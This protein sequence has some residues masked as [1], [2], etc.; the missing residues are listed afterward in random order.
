MKYRLWKNIKDQLRKDG[1]IRILENGV[2]VFEAQIGNWAQ[3]GDGAQIGNG[4]RIGNWAQIG[5][6]A[7]IGNEARIGNWAQIGILFPLVYL[8]GKWPI[9]PYAIGQIRC[10]CFIG[11]YEDLLD[12]TPTIWEQKGYSIEQ[13]D[14]AIAVVSWLQSIE[15]LVFLPTEEPK[16][17]FAK[18]VKA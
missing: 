3:I 4:A 12:R 17:N 6:W 7:R 14:A 16:A 9:H 13:R 10:G 1:H 5:N 15:G 8:H 18:K 2:V 11:K